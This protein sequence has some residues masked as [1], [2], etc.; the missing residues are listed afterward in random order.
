MQGADTVPRY[1][2]AI[3]LAL[4]AVLDKV[5]AEPEETIYSRLKRWV[6]QVFI[7]ATSYERCAI[8]VEFRSE[9]ERSAA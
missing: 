9:I 1:P 5:P 3:L 8:H 4:R 7:E 2:H 6:M